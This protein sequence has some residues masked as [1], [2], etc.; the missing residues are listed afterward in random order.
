MCLAGGSLW[1]NALQCSLEEL[2]LVA[3]LKIEW[4]LSY[5][6]TLSGLWPSFKVFKAYSSKFCISFS[7]KLEFV[8]SSCHPCL[9]CALSCFWQALKLPLTITEQSS[10]KWSNL[11]PALLKILS[12]ESGNSRINCLNWESLLLWSLLR[13]WWIARHCFSQSAVGFRLLL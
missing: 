13:W 1:T 5:D 7:L 3:I 4:P 6:C 8:S 10:P 2:K 11:C 9:C 12:C